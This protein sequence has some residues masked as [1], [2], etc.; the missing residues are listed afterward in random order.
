M[1][2]VSR[3]FPK[4]AHGKR[5]PR[6]IWGTPDISAHTQGVALKLSGSQQSPRGRKGGTLSFTV[7]RQSPKRLTCLVS[8]RFPKLA[9]G[10][11]R[12]RGILGT[13]DISAHTQ[14]VAFKFSGSQQ[15]PRGRKGGTLSVHCTQAI[16]QK[17]DVLS[18]PRHESRQLG[19][20]WSQH[21][22]S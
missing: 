22:V 3:G 12:P 21:Q 19:Q 5:R 6:G 2:L 13:P 8:R 1:C 11:R 9:H 4:L 14:G 18:V 7:L 10:Q 17:I 15:S 16:S 20:F